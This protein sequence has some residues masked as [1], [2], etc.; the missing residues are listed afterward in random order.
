MFSKYG[1]TFD[2]F[3]LLFHLCSRTM[4]E[5]IRYAILDTIDT[6]FLGLWSSVEFI[7]RLIINCIVLIIMNIII[8]C[9]GI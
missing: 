6:Y 5:L 7:L 3:V 9:I 1:L 2:V 8:V 4:T